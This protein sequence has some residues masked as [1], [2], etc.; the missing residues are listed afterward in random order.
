MGFS[1][2]YLGAF[3]VADQ[4]PAFDPP[5]YS[6][7]PC[8]R[9]QFSWS[10]P[11]ALRN[12]VLRLGMHLFRAYDERHAIR[13]RTAK[14]FPIS[15]GGIYRSVVDCGHSS[16]HAS[17]TQTVEGSQSGSARI[18]QVGSLLY[19]IFRS[20]VGTLRRTA[21]RAS[22]G[23]GRHSITRRPGEQLRFSRGHEHC[24]RYEGTP[25]ATRGANGLAAP[26][27]DCP[28]YAHSGVG[29][30]RDEDVGA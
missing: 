7:R 19:S 28:R 16:S 6:S 14:F 24:A 26:S 8:W 15:G 30:C 27:G 18:W 4:P 29:A 12:P 2:F 20:K 25:I 23:D 13:S 5:A 9:A 22:T 17:G 1:L 21:D 3:A 10:R 11:E